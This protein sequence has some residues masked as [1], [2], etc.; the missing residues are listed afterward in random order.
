[1]YFQQCRW[2]REEKG[3]EIEMRN[4]NEQRVRRKIQDIV[5]D[6]VKVR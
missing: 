3:S 4:K 2:V 5:R 6:R 1:M